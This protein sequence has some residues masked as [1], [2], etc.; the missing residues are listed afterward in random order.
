MPNRLLKRI[1]DL[2]ALRDRMQ[3]FVQGSMVNW[4]VKDIYADRKLLIGELIPELLA[5]AND[6]LQDARKAGNSTGQ[7]LMKQIGGEPT[8]GDVDFG[9][10]IE[11]TVADTAADCLRLGE[12]YLDDL[13]FEAERMGNLGVSAENIIGALLTDWSRRNRGLI[14]GKIWA[15]FSRKL[16]D[17]AVR[18]YDIS[19]NAVWFGQDLTNGN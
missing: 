2:D 19:Q 9:A 12:Q 7:A 14:N 18:L 11:N 10:L 8:A 6:I 16:S 4:N 3:E 15:G 17:L 5:G 1:Q 13:N